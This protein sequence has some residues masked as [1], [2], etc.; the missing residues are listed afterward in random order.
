MNYCMYL[1][2]SRTD[3]EAEAHNA[4]D[5][6][7]RHETLLIDLAKKHNVTISKI[8]NEIVSGETIA[9]RPVMQILL[10]EVELGKWAG[11]YVIEIERLA[12]GDTIDQGIVA[13]T[14]KYSG[15]KII[16]PLKIYD[17][18]NEYDEEY[19][20]FGLFMSR[21]EF[22]TINRRIQR[23]RIASVKEGKFIS[24]TAPYGFQREK[25][26]ND[27]GYTLI[28]LPE[29]SKVVKLI[30]EWYTTGYQLPNGSIERLGCMKI[31]GLLNSMGY[32]APKGGKWSKS[33][34][35]DILKNPVYIGYI[36]WQHRKEFTKITSNQP[37]KYRCKANDCLLEK[38]IHKPIIKETVFKKAQEQFKNRTHPPIPGNRSITNPLLGILF[39]SKCGTPL[40]KLGKSKKNSHDL[41]KCMNPKCN[42]ISTPL[43]LVEELIV[44]E[45][46]HCVRNYNYS[47]TRNEII[48]PLMQS[49]ENKKD[50]IKVISAQ[51]QR[52][53]KNYER[54]C[55]YLE[56][57]IYS[58]E[59]FCKRRIK[60][61]KDL[62]DL[63]KT[64]QLLYEEIRQLQIN[65]ENDT[66]LPEIKS[67]SSLYYS[68]ITAESKNELLKALVE[69]VEYRK[70]KKN[71][72]GDLLHCNF[73]LDIYPKILNVT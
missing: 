36:R 13:Q 47:F 8:Y 9:A 56:E 55:E 38:G 42:N 44:K 33:T 24:S 48:S 46:D 43:F 67:L 37:K 53:E 35:L 34:I 50:Y 63:N 17:P 7:L 5:T 54:V 73:T 65:I 18:S 70:D 30:Y 27:K 23:G 40:T 10:Q 28:S 52:K 72:K 45:L 12:R 62:E 6:L 32:K 49:L 11:V 20:E 22:K 59:D 16:T 61:Q 69:R 3:L 39:C 4:G 58:P 14:F 19:F 25:L 15:T 71:Q 1:R 41:I 26:A 57:G 51:I 2:K 64:Q 66:I 29:E 68:L 21:R 60:I 31:A